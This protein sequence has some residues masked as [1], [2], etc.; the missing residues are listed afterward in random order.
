MSELGKKVGEA[1]GKAFTLT[2]LDVVFK[3]GVVAAIA[4]FFV[5]HQIDRDSQ[6]GQHL[7]EE[8]KRNDEFIQ[9]K[10]LTVLEN[11]AR[12]QTELAGAIRESAEYHK[13]AQTELLSKI[14]RVVEEVDDVTDT[15]RPFANKMIAEQQ[16]R[17]INTNGRTTERPAGNSNNE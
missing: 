10:L 17:V 13:D 4:L 11:T 2:N 16:G 3:L 15:L 6:T 12:S 9:T 1:A 5:Q 8:D 14:G 7:I